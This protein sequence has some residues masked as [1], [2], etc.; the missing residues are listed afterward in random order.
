MSEAVG[1]GS[2]L[3]EAQWL[4]VFKNSSKLSGN[5]RFKTMQL[6]CLLTF[7][8]PHGSEKCKCSPGQFALSLS[9]PL[10]FWVLFSV[11]FAFPFLGTTQPSFLP[12]SR[13]PCFA[14]CLLSLVSREHMSTTVEQVQHPKPL[15]VQLYPQ[16]KPHFWTN[17]YSCFLPILRLLKWW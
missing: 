14:W 7:P 11:S 9:H 12:L 8:S 15:L 2:R 4:M 17:L 5:L 16:L 10:C 1:L 3:R 13:S 6:C